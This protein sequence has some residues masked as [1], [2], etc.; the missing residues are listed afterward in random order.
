MQAYTITRIHVFYKF[1]IFLFLVIH[2]GLSDLDVWCQL[3]LITYFCRS[4]A[5]VFDEFDSTPSQMC[6]TTQNNNKITGVLYL[7]PPSQPS[8]WS[9]KIVFDRY[10]IIYLHINVILLIASSR[11]LLHHHACHSVL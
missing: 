9:G 6:S 4:K 2:I 3:L 8:H 11:Q 5:V 10:R 7:P 1:I